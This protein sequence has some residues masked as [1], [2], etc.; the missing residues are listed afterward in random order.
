M[1]CTNE[2]DGATEAG[3]RH[4]FEP[5]CPHCGGELRVIAAITDPGV[6]MRILEHTGLDGRVQ[7]RAPPSALVN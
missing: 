4:R 3:I 2:L 5:Q 1:H 6:T 7:P